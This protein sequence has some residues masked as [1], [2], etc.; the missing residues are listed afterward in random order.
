MAGGGHLSLLPG[1]FWPELEV[2]ACCGGFNC[3]FW[4]QKVAEQEP[5]ENCIPAVFGGLQSL[6][7]L[8]AQCLAA[9]S[10]KC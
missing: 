4:C 7:P 3:W 2:P 6:K 10:C 5:I 1:L 8:C 9:Y